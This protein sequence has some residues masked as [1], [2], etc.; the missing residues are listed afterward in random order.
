ML[1]QQ[2]LARVQLG[3]HVENFGR[4]ALQRGA[5]MG[6]GELPGELHHEGADL[7]GLPLRVVDTP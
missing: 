7:S 2:D 5:L 3:A 4:D 1:R 6:V